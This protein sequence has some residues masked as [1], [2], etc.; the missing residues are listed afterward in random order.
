MGFVSFAIHPE[1]VGCIAVIGALALGAIRQITAWRL[2]PAQPQWPMLAISACG[3]VFCA[4]RVVHLDGAPDVA[5]TMIRCQYG[6]G[7]VLPGFGMAAIELMTE[8]QISAGTR[9]ALLASAILLAVCVLS[10]WIVD[11]PITPHLDALG[12][13]HYG[14]RPGWLTTLVLPTAGIFTFIAIRR[15]LRALPPELRNQ[16]RGFLLG[17]L[18]FAACGLNDSLA[19]AGV[20]SSV[21]LLDY[22]F[23]AFGVLAANY[24]LRRTAVAQDRLAAQLAAKR[25]TLEQREYSLAQTTRRLE[26]SNSRYR[27]LADATREGVILCAG[28]RVLDVNDAACRILGTPTLAMKPRNLRSADLRPFVDAADRERMAL[29]LDQTEGPFEITLLR[30]DETQIPVSI[31]SLPAPSGSHGTRV[32]LLRDVSAERELQRRLAT[33]DRLAAVGTLAAGTAHEINNPLTFVLANAELLEETVAQL[34]LPPAVAAD[35]RSLLEDITQGGHRIRD[36]VKN[37]MSLARDRGE[38]A[39]IDVRKT[40]QHCITMAKPQIRHRARV[41]TAFEDMRPVRANE[42]RLFQVFLNLVVNAAHAIGEGHADENEIRVCGRS[43]GAWTVIEVGDTGCGMTPAVLDRIF[44][45]FF[46]TK[47][48]GQGTGLGL[49]ISHGIVSDLGGRIEVESTVGVGTTFR[50]YLP[51][52]D[53]EL[54]TTTQPQP[55][56]DAPR[57]RILIVDDEVALTRSLAKILDKH[58]VDV[59]NSGRDAL[60]LIARHRYDVAICDVMMPDITGIQLFQQLRTAN[61]PII[62]RF[63]FI[64]GGVSTPESQRFLDEIGQRRWLAKP[65]PMTELRNRVDKLGPA[66]PR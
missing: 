7:L 11:A 66:P 25:T 14:A 42:G 65:I 27:H 63:L 61:D 43:E 54:A 33:A 64:T 46:T 21:F 41:V 23:V 24:E 20:V 55:V 26:D 10:P 58:D 30:T 8:R 52:S 6:I 56:L 13:V 9:W 1:A 18:V 4:T 50:V 5:L 47:E 44:E 59:T 19:G 22:A 16:R 29:L 17:I 15:R 62:D 51:A 12:H 2:R 31:K 60:E 37:L 40:L 39:V 36:V 45:P 35:A 3:I 32:L 48:L 34:D 28:T 49:S 38:V 57:L 53:G